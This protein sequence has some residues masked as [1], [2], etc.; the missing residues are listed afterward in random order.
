MT[1]LIGHSE[2]KIKPAK[3]PKAKKEN[4]SVCYKK[5]RKG[6]IMKEWHEEASW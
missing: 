1:P 6:L 2:K 3:N 4:K 5:W